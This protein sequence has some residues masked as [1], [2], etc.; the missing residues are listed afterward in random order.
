[1]T[2]FDRI[3]LLPPD[4]IEALDYESTFQEVLADFQEAMGPGW[5]APVES[6]PAMK[7]LEVSA[8]REILQRARYNDEARAL[9]LAYAVGNALDHIGVTYYQ[10][11][12]LVIVPADPAADPPVEE[13]R[14]EDDDYRE[15]CWL[16]PA[17]YSVAGPT[18]AYEYLARKAS[19]SVRDAKATSPQ[20]GTTVVHVLSRDGNGVPAPELLEVV[21]AALDAEL[22]RPLSE[23]VIA[24]AAEVEEYAL[25]VQ[26]HVYD[27]NGSDLLM[28]SA[29]SRL[30]KFTVEHHRLGHDITVSAVHG[31]AWSVGV[32]KVTVPSL[33]ADIL[34]DI[35]QAAYCTSILVEVVGVAT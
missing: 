33:P 15:R 23:D 26:L 22:V 20:G 17:S 25:V 16:R 11:L 1:M 21:Q 7:L 24:L 5:S 34:R 19:G 18:A 30:A 28:A 8:W 14:E 29:E 31:A 2:I 4:V 3:G 32:Q 6:D 13:V 9:L 12:R 27:L 10:T 35:H